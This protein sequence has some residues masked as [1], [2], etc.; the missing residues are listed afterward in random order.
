MS[1]LR[2]RPVPAFGAFQ[3]YALS[4]LGIGLLLA[5]PISRLIY[6]PAWFTSSIVSGVYPPITGWLIIALSCLGVTAL[7]GVVALG[8]ICAGTLMTPAFEEGRLGGQLRRAA[9]L[10]SAT[11]AEARVQISLERK[12]AKGQ[13]ID[14]ALASSGGATGVLAALL[15]KQRLRM[16]RLS[17]IQVVITLVAPVL[18][19]VV[20]AVMLVALPRITTRI[21]VLAPAA[22]FACFALIRS[23]VAI[24]RGDFAH[25]DFFTAWPVSRLQLVGYDS[26][27]GFVLPLLGGE[28]ALLASTA[29]AG[30]GYALTW[31]IFWPFLIASCALAAALDF[32]RLLRKWP[33]TPET[34]PDVGPAAVILAGIIW[35]IVMWAVQN[36]ATILSGN[37]VAFR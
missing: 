14:A 35:L 37:S 4:A 1:L 24:L 32:L 17:P 22:F 2:Y 3:G 31:M 11:A 5:L 6:W 16:A 36:G 7:A 30:W 25:I 23:G 15:L 33:A 21:E 9:S 26:I 10:G 29:F 19:G 34:L 20:V 8:V 27:M 18:L 12:M 13:G 28:I